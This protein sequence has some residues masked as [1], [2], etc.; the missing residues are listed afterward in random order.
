MGQVTIYL[1]NEIE[2]KMVLAAQAAHLSKSKWIARIIKQ[3]IANEWSDSIQQLSGSWQ[4]FPS[5]DEL[6]SNNG[7]DAPRE[8]I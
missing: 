1:D 3:N 4:D 6:R 2:Q 5:I 8:T 7:V